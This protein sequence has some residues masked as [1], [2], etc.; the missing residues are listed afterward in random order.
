VPDPPIE[1]WVLCASWP[2]S[3]AIQ[4]KL[5]ELLDPA[6]LDPRTRT[7]D[8]KNGF[9]ANGPVVMLRN[10]SVIRFRTTQQSGLDLAGA[11]IDVA[12]FDEPPYSQR[13]FSEVD[14][15][16][17]RT[18]GVLLMTLTPIN[19]PTDWLR[20][21]AEGGGLSDHHY[22][23]EPENLIPVGASQPLT[24]KDGTP[25]DQV[26]I[27][28]VVSSSLAHEIPVVCHGEWELRTMSR[29]FAAFTDVEHISEAPPR[30]KCELVLGIDH[31]S[32][33]D[34]SQVAILAAVAKGPDWERVWVL[35]EYIATQDTTT[36]NDADSIVDMLARNG[37]R[38]D[39]LDHIHGDRSWEGRKST[40]A[41]KSNAL[42]MQAIGRRLGHDPSPDIRT[43]KRGHGRGKG[44]ID[45]GGRYL[46]QCMVRPGHFSVHPRCTRLIESMN[47]WDFSDSEWKHAIDGLRYSLDHLIFAPNRRSG[48]PPVLLYG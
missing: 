48:G 43:V 29:Y 5:N 15:R 45:A 37:I 3:L 33:G 1:A 32:G 25:M 24:L 47:R 6:E 17:L 8:P 42:L 36:Q 34:F 19:R 26:W 30:G 10:G 11:T 4:G 28:A 23:L 13:V 44:S 38:W 20:E 35:D 22:R 27:D 18:N 31:G 7:F 9:G 46:H 14:K 21:L 12:L 16:R 39:E 41:R 2:Q 40:H